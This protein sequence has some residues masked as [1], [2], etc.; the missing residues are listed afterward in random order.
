MASTLISGS[1]E[2]RI[3]Q[4]TDDQLM[5]H[6]VR[7]EKG[8]FDELYAR[9]KQPLYNY[10]YRNCGDRTMVDELYQNVWLRVLAAAKRYKNTGRFRSWLF[11]LAHNCLVDYYRQAEKHTSYFVALEPAIE[12]N[13]S[14]GILTETQISDLELQQSINQSIANIPAEQREAFCLREEAGFSIK[15]IALI[16]GVTQEAAK[17]RLR[18]AYKKLRQDLQRHRQNQP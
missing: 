12:R 9:Y 3:G 8:A 1:A 16:Q 2:K 10:L 13:S 17:S 7:G 5:L 11:T 15:E 14:N 4:K 18:Y 6:Y